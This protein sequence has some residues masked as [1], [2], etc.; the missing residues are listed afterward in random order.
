MQR[1]K[2]HIHQSNPDLGDRDAGWSC[3][4]GKVKKGD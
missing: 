3:D 1:D 2:L 4:H